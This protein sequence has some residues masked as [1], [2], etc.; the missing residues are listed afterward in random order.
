MSILVTYASR[1]GATAGVARVIGETLREGTGTRVD[2][3]P[4]LDVPH[5]DG[6]AAVVAGSAIQDRRW[7]PEAMDF[8]RAN[9]PALQALPTALFQVCI[10]LGMKNGA[11]YRA[12]VDTWMEPACAIVPPLRRASFPGALDPASLPWNKDGIGLRISVMLGIMPQGDR[13]DWD[14]VHAWARDL[15][16]LLLRP[17]P[18]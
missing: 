15:R 17:T 2:V 12:G 11:A 7:L 5:L 9:Q 18:A 16:T 13:R 10:T 14:A 6:Y 3:M 1:H 8:L 4:M